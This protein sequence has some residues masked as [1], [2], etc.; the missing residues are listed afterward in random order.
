MGHMYRRT[1]QN[2]ASWQAKTC[3]IERVCML[4]LMQLC[5]SS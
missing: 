4:G 1:E 3:C 5:E 2:D